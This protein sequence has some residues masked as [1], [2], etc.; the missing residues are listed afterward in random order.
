[1]PQP[2]WREDIPRLVRGALSRQQRGHWNTT[3]ANAWGTLAMEKFSAAFEAT[4]VAGTS[5]VRYATLEHPIAWPLNSASTEIDLP[6]AEGAGTLEVNHNGG[7]APWTL[8][9]ATA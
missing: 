4:P 7:G 1:I 2:G 9:R 3:V 8:I 6:W 5:I